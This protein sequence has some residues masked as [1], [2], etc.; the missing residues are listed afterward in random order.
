M[1]FSFCTPSRL[2]GGC[3][4]ISNYFSLLF[5]VFSISKM[6]KVSLL[7]T[8]LS[9]FLCACYSYPIPTGNCPEKCKCGREDVDCS[10]FRTI[11]I[12]PDMSD[13]TVSEYQFQRTGIRYLN[14]SRLGPIVR[15][16]NVKYTPI[17]IE[18]FCELTTE[19]DRLKGAKFV[20]NFDDAD[21][22]CSKVQEIDPSSNGASTGEVKFSE[23]AATI[24][25]MNCTCK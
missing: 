5:P 1:L 21:Y 4:S 16:L 12:F 2:A 13:S 22:D 20:T 10:G 18:N 23:V 14:C 19:C 17:K 8:I 25:A 9:L 15:L 7:C 3:L 6:K 24:L 11:K